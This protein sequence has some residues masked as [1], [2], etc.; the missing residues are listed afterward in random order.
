MD[1]KAIQKQPE[2]D[3]V[4]EVDFAALFAELDRAAPTALIEGGLNQ[5]CRAV[6]HNCRRDSKH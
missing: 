5:L 6:A 2:L 1:D 4:A 3:R